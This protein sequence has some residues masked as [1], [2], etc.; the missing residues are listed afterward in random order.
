[1][2]T[3]QVKVEKAK[4]DQAKIT[5]TIR[6]AGHRSTVKGT[7]NTKTGVVSGPDLSFGNR[8]MSGSFN[9]YN[10]I[11]ARNLFTSKRK[12]EVTKANDLLKPWLGTINVAWDDGA[13]SA[14]IS[15]K[16]KVKL[17]GTVLNGVKLSVSSQLIIG[18]NMLCIPVTPEK[19][20]NISFLLSLPVNGGRATVYGLQNAIVGKPGALPA[21][22]AIFLID[23]DAIVGIAALSAKS[24]IAAIAADNIPDGVS[25][26]AGPQTPSKLKINNKKKTGAF[27][28]SFKVHVVNGKQKAITVNVAGVTIDNAG[29]G[30]AYIKKA[31][32]TS[33]MIR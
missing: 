17:S 28:G 12:T 18:E 23:T 31:G 20:T 30:I 3:I 6:L 25:L 10:I 29:Y 22:D 4:K 19:K 9:G 15:Q 2:G 26:K 14:T 8:S 24:S 1:M 7:L 11:G 27:S 21:N 16:G 5:A 32:L 33:I 13:V